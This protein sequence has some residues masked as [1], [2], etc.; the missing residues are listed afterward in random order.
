MKDGDRYSRQTRFA[1]IGPAG[2]A[3]LR[4]GFVT[5]IGCGALGSGVA[6]SL[7]RAGVGRLR[8]VDRDLLEMSNLARQV[9]FEEE[10]V[11]RGLPKAVAAAG[12]LRKINSEVQ[13]EPVFADV[14]PSNV[15]S[16]I[17]GS[18]VV[19]DGSDNMELRF[20][21]N[22][23]CVKMNVPWVYGGAAAS[24]GMTMTILPGRGPCLRC[25]IEELPAP[26]ALRTT[27]EVG[28]LNTL[29][30]MVSAIESNEALKLLLGSGP[31]NT[32]LLRFDIWTLDFQR[33]RVQRRADCPTCGLRR[34]ERLEAPS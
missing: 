32:S 6:L 34:F 28:V 20:L 19:T 1:E 25:V 23:A 31:P 16:L 30:G 17:E 9:L 11:R 33:S 7:G 18:D 12:R 10:D 29:T 5:I 21:L 27:A 4:G 14:T 13:V 22:E 8:I 2:Q 24:R 3:R 15:L 26:G